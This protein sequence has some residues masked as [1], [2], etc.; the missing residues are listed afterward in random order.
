MKIS[1]YAVKHPRIIGMLL[2]VLITFGFISLSG[3]NVAFMGEL[4]LP[5]IAVISI[6]PGAGAQDVERDVTDILENDFATLNGLKN[7]TS[8]SKDSLSIITLFFQDG[9]DPYEQLAE[10][11]NRINKK[12][13]DLPDGLQGIPDA[14]V[15]GSE[16]L[17]VI[18]FSVSGAEDSARLS[19]Y[20]DD[21]LKPRLTSLSGVSQVSVAGSKKPIV[22]V[23]LRTNDLKAKQ[24]SVTDVY[25]ALRYANIKLPAGSAEYQ[26]RNIDI[27]YDA[28]LQTID[29]IQNI[30][31]GIGEHNVIIKLKD[32]ADIGFDYPKAESIVSDG[33]KSIVVIDIKKRS[34]ANVMKIAKDVKKI[35]A[36]SAA[37]TH[38]AIEYSII[39]DDSRVIKASVTTVVTSGIT[40][41]VMAI[42][43]LFLFLNDIKATCIIGM[44]IPLSILFTFIG[45]KILGISINLMSLSGMVTA[46]GMVVDASIVMI[47][48]VYRYYKRIPI[49]TDTENTDKEDFTEKLEKSIYTGADEVGQAILSG[50]ATTVVV[51]LPIALLNGLI[52]MML[53]DVAL[54][55]ILALSASLFTAL[56]IVPFLMRLLLQKQN[57]KEKKRSLFNVQIVKLEKQ[58]ERVLTK[59]LKV[60]KTVIGISVLILV[61]TLFLIR[62]LGISFLPIIDN[63]DYY[64]ALSFPAGYSLEQTH[65]HMTKAAQLIKKNIPEVQTTILYS[66]SADNFISSKGN[67]NEAFTHIILKP[68]SQRKKNIQNIITETQRLLSLSIPD[69]QITVTNGGFNRLLGYVA[70]GGGFGIGLEG[71]NIQDLYAES[72][73]LYHFLKED[74]ETLSVKTDTAFDSTSFVLAIK[75]EYM[76][77]LGINNYEAALSSVILFQG[78]NAGRFT[79]KLSGKRYDIYLSSDITDTPLNSDTLAAIEIKNGEGH[80]V[81]FA[82]IADEKIEQNLSSINHTNRTKS[83]NISAVLVN[84]NTAGIHKRLQS[85]LQKNPLKRGIRSKSI[86]I[87]ELLEDSLPRMIRALLIA[88]FLVYTAMV[89]QFERFRQPLLVMGAIPFSIIGVTFGLLI[90]GST[91]SL[92][93]LLGII[94]LAGIVVNNGIILIDYINLIR[95]KQSKTNPESERTLI[96]NIIKACASRVRPILMTTLTTLLGIIPM[97]LARGEGAETYTALAQAIAGG[98]VSST[99]ISLLLIPVL[100]YLTELRRLNIQQGIKNKIPLKQISCLFIVLLS[101]L[102]AQ[103]LYGQKTHDSSFQDLSSQTQTKVYTYSDLLYAAEQNNPAIRKAREEFLQSTFDTKNAKGVLQPHIDATMSASYLYNNPLPDIYMDAKTLLP[104]AIAQTMGDGT[105]KIMD[106]PDNDFRLSL[107]VAQPI[108]LWEKG[109][110]AVSMYT[111][112]SRIKRD[113]LQDTHNKIEIEIKTRL[114]ALYYLQAMLL[115]TDEQKNYMRALSRTADHAAQKGSILEQEAAKIHLNIGEIEIAE[116]QIRGSIAEHVLELQ[117]LTGLENLK[118]EN[119]PCFP[120]PK[121]SADLG[122][123]NIEASLRRI[124]TEKAL[125]APEGSISAAKAGLR[126]AELANNISV[127]DSYGIP[128]I[129]LSGKLEYGGSVSSFQNNDFFTKDKLKVIITVSMNSTLWDGGKKI[130]EQKRSQS[131][132]NEAQADFDA[133]VFFI[134]ELV[135][136]QLNTIELCNIR[137]AHLGEK[138]RITNKML[139]KHV[140]MFESGSGSETEVLQSRAEK[141]QIKIQ[142]LEQ[143][144]IRDAALFTLEYL[145]GAPL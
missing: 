89:L 27:R 140:H 138:E 39:N 54:T 47:E 42:L 106:F 101:A 67:P 84:D 71:E 108:F 4:S 15:G 22:S 77:E 25:N 131:R 109:F 105:K 126:A 95:S 61:F 62:L 37:D 58:Y 60:P 70:G 28:S 80:M 18:S 26:K 53:K 74:S 45:M 57:V 14:L 117:T 38:G 17:P 104:P 69:A 120:H 34:G 52:G 102:S 8:S 92:I 113:M 75:H 29:H 94:S 19:E 12:L 124:L 127:L 122:K 68:R 130:N 129:V 110:K 100:Y 43:I 115:L 119:L 3:I 32:I 133:A 107:S 72:L 9:I 46:L 59:A 50:A 55:L 143:H 36:E 79:D 49:H 13:E 90:F 6:Y 63:S 35:L 125:S 121:T 51:F 142:L 85:Y 16:M 65:M 128:D 7:I 118:A 23:K 99:L 11:R 10:V 132:E 21:R 91:M 44:S 111:V 83:I 98:L 82:S 78:L 93:A 56:I 20:I 136:K 145:T 87:M 31:V 103:K 134:K 30:T 81:S 2:I 1:H 141:T 88:C 97:A 123:N 96:Q 66:G 86:G 139:E 135:H 64:A 41:V 48:Q 137:S 73:R 33:E 116:A 5:S 40:G 24:I 144:L 114:C 76:N 112:I